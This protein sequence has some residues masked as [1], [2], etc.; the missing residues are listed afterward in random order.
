M[1]FLIHCRFHLQMFNE[2]KQFNGYTRF[3]KTQCQCEP[4][5]LY[6]FLFFSVVSLSVNLQIIAFKPSPSESFRFSVKICSLSAITGWPQQIFH[7]GPKPTL[8]GPGENV[9][10]SILPSEL[11]PSLNSIFVAIVSHNIPAR[12]FSSE[13]NT[14]YSSLLYPVCLNT[15][16][17]SPVISFTLYH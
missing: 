5:M 11:K 13:P 8:S 17:Q 4:T 7:R 14:Q 2:V 9:R 3:S 10:K 1:R 6:M 12:V 16:L 15:H